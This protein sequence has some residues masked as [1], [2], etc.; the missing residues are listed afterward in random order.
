MKKIIYSLVIMIAAGSL[1]TSCIEQ[2]EPEGILALRE[3]KARYYDAL[4]QLRAKDGLY[5]EAEAAL[6]NAEA[7]LKQAE[8]AHQQAVTDAYTKMQALLRE[9]QQ[10]ENE[11]LAIQNEAAAL[12][13]EKKAA[14]VAQAIDKIQ[15]EMEIAEKDHEINLVKKQE[16][17]A[18]AQEALRVALRDI[19]LAAQDL[20]ANEKA[21]VIAAAEAYWELYKKVSDQ[22]I[23]V[24]KAEQ[25][26]AKAERKRDMPKYNTKDYK[27]DPESHAYKTMIEYYEGNIERAKGFIA[28]DEAILENLPALEDVEE[29]G[30]ELEGY[31]KAAKELEYSEYQLGQDVAYYY[32]NNIHDGIK[33]FNDAIDAWKE[34][35]EDAVK[36]E[37]KEPKEP[38]QSEYKTNTA[39]D[40]LKI[41]DIKVDKNDKGFIIY[42]R[43]A[44]LVGELDDLPVAAVEGFKNRNQKIATVEL[45]GDEYN[46]HLNAATSV[47]NLILGDESKWKVGQKTSDTYKYGEKGRDTTVTVKYGAEGAISILRRELVIAEQAID[48][49]AYKKAA[50]TA[51]NK[52][53][54]DRAVLEKGL[55]EYDSYKTAKTNLDKAIAET[56]SL[57][58]LMVNAVHALINGLMDINASDLSKVDSTHL[59]KVFADFAA[60]RED[61]FKYEWDPEGTDKFDRHFYWYGNT[62]GDTLYFPFRNLNYD[63]LAANRTDKKKFGTVVET[64]QVP[65]QTQNHAFGHIAY[66]L[67]NETYGKEISTN[68]A[69]W[70]FSLANINDDNCKAFYNLYKYIPESGAGKKDDH[71]VLND[72]LDTPFESPVIT[73]AKKKVDDAIKAYMTIYNNYWIGAD[74]KT[75]CGILT[76]A[77]SEDDVA[78]A[79]EKEIKVG[80]YNENTFAEPYQIVSFVGDDIIFNDGLG[81]IL[82]FIDPKVKKAEVKQYNNGSN[83][84]I[85]TTIFGGATQPSTFAKYLKAK[86]AYETLG[87]LEPL[88]AA[89]DRIEKWVTEEVKAK[90]QAA[91]DGNNKD[92]VNAYNTAHDTWQDE[93][94]AWEEKNESYTT[95]MADLKAF[96]GVDEDDKPLTLDP[97]T[98]KIP[99]SYRG[100]VDKIV[101]TTDPYYVFPNVDVK[102][103]EWDEEKLGGELLALAEECFP[104]LPETMNEWYETY[105][106]IQDK[107]NHNKYLVS[108]LS[109]VYSASA[110]VINHAEYPTWKR[111]DKGDITVGTTDIYD[112]DF[113]ELFK[114]YK[115]AR[116]DYEKAVKGDIDDQEKVIDTNMQAIADWESGKDA[117]EIAVAEAQ[118]KLDKEQKQL[119]VY[120]ELL[121][122]AKENLDRILEYLLSQDVNFINLANTNIGTIIK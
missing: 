64:P 103:G 109:P 100:G 90:I 19:A 94:D 51:E 118:A 84:L 26:L 9:K 73:E 3:A 10:L 29:W 105:V 8:T 81:T 46:V 32:V 111:D 96:V 112:A 56:D 22:E 12:D 37:P 39:K 91:V 99:E 110:K 23:V 89:L 11:L 107:I 102:K 66:Q 13:L 31:Q 68:P 85:P 47:K 25:A 61:Y 42:K 24:M 49:E 104:A 98:L 38:K 48:E 54:A 36:T 65:Y 18:K 5:R 122:A 1:F 113:V 80:I 72:G 93:H 87:N 34:A 62:I 77:S 117:K 6:K 115:K 40:S 92:D 106:D 101:M 95:Y 20:T 88:K 63:V 67:L 60:A 121:K 76:N 44:D 57:G 50:E 43:F 86:Q 120:Q 14:E 30:N 71:F 27:W 114:N 70:A 82:A 4:A 97:A 17:L 58:D 108:F 41:A 83:M 16:E 79:R 2:V 74:Y 119:K 55:A 52:W 28:E 15:K 116:E 78:A 7:A 33:T 21:C 53:K 75:E 35:R 45:K 69:P 59:M